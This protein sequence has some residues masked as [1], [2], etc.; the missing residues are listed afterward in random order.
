MLRR[1]M[2]MSLEEHSRVEKKEDTIISDQQPG[3]LSFKF[4]SIYIQIFRC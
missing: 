1:A 4:E 2:A 3:E